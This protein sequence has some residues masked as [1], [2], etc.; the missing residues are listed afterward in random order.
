[1]T[2]KKSKTAQQQ[3]QKQDK[4]KQCTK[5]GNYHCVCTYMYKIVHFGS[6]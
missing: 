6:L 3:T 5:R 2:K 4:N 1:M